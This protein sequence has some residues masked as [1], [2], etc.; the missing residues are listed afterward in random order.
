MEIGGKYRKFSWAQTNL[1][2]I[3]VIRLKVSVNHTPRK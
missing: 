2:Q 1:I 3:I